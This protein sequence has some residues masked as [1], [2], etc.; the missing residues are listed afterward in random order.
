MDL[1]EVKVGE[2]CVVICGVTDGSRCLR[3]GSL[4]VR[5][6]RAWG[7]HLPSSLGPGHVTI[8][9]LCPDMSSI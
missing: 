6:P 5:Q 1:V 2:K 4:V 3:L 7:Y 9:L 8:L